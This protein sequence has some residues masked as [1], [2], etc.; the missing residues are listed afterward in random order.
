MY[1]GIFNMC[2]G[3]KRSKNC[4]KPYNEVVDKRSM[5]EAAYYDDRW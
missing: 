2:E 3:K 5:R 1:E 4:D